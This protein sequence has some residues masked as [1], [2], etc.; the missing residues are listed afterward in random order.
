M[1]KCNKWNR[2][3]IGKIQLIIACIQRFVIVKEPKNLYKSKEKGKPLE[4][5]EL[6]LCWEQLK[7]AKVDAVRPREKQERNEGDL[8]QHVD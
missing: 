2:Y 5:F 8:D 6:L 4:S 3:K 1:Q 7:K